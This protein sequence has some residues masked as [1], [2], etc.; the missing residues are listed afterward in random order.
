MRADLSPLT[1]QLRDELQGVLTSAFDQR[2]MEE[3]ATMRLAFEEVKFA[4]EVNFS[5]PRKRIAFDMVEVAIQYGRLRELLLAVQAARPK[6]PDVEKLVST[7]GLTAAAATPQPQPVPQA[8]RAAVDALKAQF[9]L[10][11]E[12]LGQLEAYYGLHDV[13][14]TVESFG[15]LLPS[16]VARWLWSPSDLPDKGSIIERLTECLL[17]AQNCVQRTAMPGNPPWWVERFE[18]AVADLSAELSKP[19]PASIDRWRVGVAM[20][21]LRDIP[22]AAQPVLFHQVLE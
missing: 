19:D 11:Q 16:G 14:N 9:Q 20:R 3:F 10:R 1:T 6:R 4:D 8:V 15:Q 12:Q 7:F 5:Q 22:A 13:L 18:K 17:D 21:I 2:G